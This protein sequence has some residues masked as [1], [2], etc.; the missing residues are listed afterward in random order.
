[1][2]PVKRKI[3]L[4]KETTDTK[5][6][7]RPRTR[8]CRKKNENSTTTLLEELES[9]AVSSSQTKE[10]KKKLR[11]MG[12]KLSMHTLFLCICILMLLVIAL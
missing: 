9:A 11:K 8:T 12:S 3:V 2:A 5:I 1:M 4:T 10:N 7:K 6:Q